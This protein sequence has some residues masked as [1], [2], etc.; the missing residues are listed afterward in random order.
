[1]AGYVPKSGLARWLDQRLPIAR[2]V[3]DA[4]V[5]SQTPK[6][7]NVWYAFGAILLTVLAV[8]F[9]TGIVLSMHYVPDA[10]LA[11]ASVEQHIMRE[12]R[13]GWLIR[14]LH[15]TG[16]S[17]IF[18]AVY[19]HMARSLYYGSYKAP[20]EMVW[21]L[22]VVLYYLLVATAFFGTVLPFGQ[23]SYWSATVLTNLFS[24]FD[25]IVPGAGSAITGWLLGGD[26]VSGVTLNR[27]F[28]F[29]IFLP[30]VLVGV[31]GLH[32][33]AKHVA[34][35]NNPLGVEVQAPQDTLPFH[36]HFTS[37]HAF[38]TAL[39]FA[40]FLGLV[41]YA[42]DLFAN[43]ENASP[44]DPLVAPQLI[45]PEWYVLPYYAMVRAVPGKLMGVLVLGAALLTWLALP[46]LDTSKVRSCRYRPVM[47]QLFW[48]FIANF[49]LLGIAGYQSADASWHV[50]VIDIAQVWLARLCTL[51]YFAFFWVLLPLLG[52]KEVPLPVPDSITPAVKVE[53]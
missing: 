44:A 19:I 50:G 22:G 29:H 49:I 42:P 8:Q 36:P 21:I 41:F 3:H 7:L 46:W 9:L 38:Y 31:I 10:N 33:W 25:G 23:M 20:R 17:M 6:N 11:F 48:V 15:A 51:F 52:K 53:A 2:L 40:V 4:V 12:V 16:A 43:P 13:Y 32:L 30:F 37:K 34:G 26:S 24:A 47:K 39:F 18:V 28:A 1:M 35:S 27:I 45:K 5:S 14:S